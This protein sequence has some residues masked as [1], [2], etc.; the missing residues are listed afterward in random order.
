M[1]SLLYTVVGN[2]SLDGSWLVT[3]YLVTRLYAMNY[4]YFN[5]T[6]YQKSTFLISD[7]IPYVVYN[8]LVTIHYFPLYNFL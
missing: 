6:I 1:C 4:S 3:H 8:K 5:M 2:S 7:N